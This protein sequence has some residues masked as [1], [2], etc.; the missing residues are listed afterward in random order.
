MP[1]LRPRLLGLASIALFGAFAGACANGDA[2]GED[3]ETEQMAENSE[4]ALAIRTAERE[5]LDDNLPEAARLLNDALSSDSE[6]PA[7]W[8]A[9][10]RL[11]FRGG[12]HLSAI[13]AA[14]RALELG[15]AY[16]PALLMRGQLVRDSNGL[17]ESLPWFEA[18]IKVDPEDVEVLGEYAATLGDLGRHREMLSA[19]DTLSAIDKENAQGLYLRAVL[20]A[21][22][23]EPVLARS[24][25]D[26][27]GWRDAGIPSVMLLDAVIDIQQGNADTAVETLAALCLLQPANRRV[28]DLY[29]RAL[30]DAGRDE[31]LISDFRSV[32]DGPDASAYITMMVGRAYERSGQRER[33]A[34]LL[35]KAYAEQPTEAVTLAEAG[36]IGG[37]LPSQTSQIRLAV[38]SGDKAG[39]ATQASLYKRTFPQSAD[40]LALAGDVDLSN[41][42]PSSAIASY[43]ESARVRRPWPMTR[44]L[45]EASR[46]AGEGEAAS[47]IV[48]RYSLSDPRNAEAIIAVLNDAKQDEE[49]DRV[50]PIARYVVALG[51]GHDPSVLNAMVDASRAQGDEAKATRYEKLLEV[52]RPSKLVTE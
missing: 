52:V 24:L 38:A 17:A 27:S 10:A 36:V 11:R 4:V 22:A 30:W 31:K 12:E 48:S 41:Q 49:W 16:G 26:R 19:V 5:M 39:A 51:A 35:A 23:G 21:R 29:A 44:K 8:V 45:V 43:S 33:A 40:I 47:A 7:I 6:N 1:N 18:A 42:K 34:P 32:L 13:D 46:M 50:S 9:V 14:E 3:A 25:L 20:A 28:R 37:A 2:G 15:P